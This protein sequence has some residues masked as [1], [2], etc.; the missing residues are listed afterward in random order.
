M[1][2]AEA[3]AVRNV[4]LDLCVTGGLGVVG[5]LIHA[6]TVE[7]GSPY[8]PPTSQHGAMAHFDPWGVPRPCWHCSRYVRLIHAGTAALCNLPNG[9]RVRS[10]PERGCCSWQREP[11]A[12]DEPGP[13]SGMGL[14]GRCPQCA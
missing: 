10:M 13:P 11:G 7:P 6:V 12:D 2:A 5:R 14:Q 4:Q 9:P 1:G 3:A 8:E